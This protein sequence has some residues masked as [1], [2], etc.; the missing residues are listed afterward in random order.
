MA[1]WTELLDAISIDLI[2]EQDKGK[3]EAIVLLKVQ[4]QDRPRLFR[5]DVEVVA[6]RLKGLLL[7]QVAGMYVHCCHIPHHSLAS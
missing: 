2:S 3:I 1:H 5:G 6:A 4:E 7:V